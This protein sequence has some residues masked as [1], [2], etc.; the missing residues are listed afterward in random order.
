M[1]TRCGIC[2]VVIAEEGDPEVRAKWRV[3]AASPEHKAN[4]PPSS[5]EVL[6]EADKLLVKLKAFRKEVGE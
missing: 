3:H 2:D 6:M 1:T 5:R 4:T